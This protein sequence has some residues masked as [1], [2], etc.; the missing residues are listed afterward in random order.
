[1]LLSQSDLD[2]MR[3]MPTRSCG[4]CHAELVHDYCRDHDEFFERG[5]SDGCPDR[6]EHEQHRTYARFDATVESDLAE[7]DA[8]YRA[9]RV[10]SAG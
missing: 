3:V 7:L 10:L 8:A 6:S 9:E 2:R 1:M 4:H 5:H